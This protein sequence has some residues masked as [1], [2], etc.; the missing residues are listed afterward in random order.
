MERAQINLS[1]GMIVSI[2]LIIIFLT[3]GGWAIWKFLNLN[4]N[5]QGGQ[6]INAIQEDIDA[7]WRST[8]FGVTQKTYVAPSRVEAVCFVDFS[9]SARGAQSALMD[10]LSLA[11]YGS[12]NFVFYP[13]GSVEG[14][15]ST[16]INHLDLPSI[17]AREN[18]YCVTVEDGK[19]SLTLE[20]V[21]GEALIRVR[22]E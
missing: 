5:L 16:T 14:L 9:S 13:F 20:K 1:F 19:I 18:P 15:E 4:A 3:F 7:L 17:V 10:D 22:R 2:V 11:N 21:R 12:E 6:V 8:T